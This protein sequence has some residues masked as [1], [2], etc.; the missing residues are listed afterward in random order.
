MPGKI[1][2]SVVILLALAAIVG[3][4][5]WLAGRHYQPTIDRLNEALTQCKASN[6]QQAA[7]ITS[8]NAGIEA[9]QRKQ[10]EIEAKVKAAQEK[11]RREAQGDYERANAVMA[12]RTTGEVCAAASAAFDVE[13]SRERAK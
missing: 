8:Q 1:T 11:S 5:A 4:G 13:L 12:E 9:L 10:E 2:S 6:K 7:T 3:A